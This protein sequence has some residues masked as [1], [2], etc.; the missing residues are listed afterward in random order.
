MK[1]LILEKYL[2]YEP[3]FSKVARQIKEE[4]DEVFGSLWHCILGKGF[5]FEV[6]FEKENLLYACIDEE[7]AVLLW[8]S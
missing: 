4:M 1:N 6:S 7:V 3:D 8:K 5:G 2:V